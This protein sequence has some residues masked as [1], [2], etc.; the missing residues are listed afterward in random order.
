LARRIALLLPNAIVWFAVAQRL[1]PKEGP[2][3]HYRQ[4]S[5]RQP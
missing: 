4:I 5:P 2:N 3:D 1:K